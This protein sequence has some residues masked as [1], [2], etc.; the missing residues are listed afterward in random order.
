[1]G[2]PRTG[3]PAHKKPQASGNKNPLKSH[4]IAPN[5]IGSRERRD[6]RDDTSILQ[7]RNYEIVKTAFEPF[8]VGEMACIDPGSSRDPVEAVG[9]LL[10]HFLLI[11]ITKDAMRST[12]ATNGE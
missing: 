6:G 12:V 5:T 2:T 7:A 3:Y 1:M 8:R 4:H 9:Y 11:H 10:L